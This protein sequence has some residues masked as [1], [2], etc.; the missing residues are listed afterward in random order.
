MGPKAVVK[1]NQEGKIENE[2]ERVRHFWKWSVA[3]PWQCSTILS[4]CMSSLF[5]FTQE[6]KPKQWLPKSKPGPVNA[7]VHTTRTKQMI[8]AFFDSKG[9]V[10][11]NHMPKGPPWTLATLWM[12]WTCSWR[13]WRRRGGWQWQSKAGGSW[14]N[15]PVH[16]TA[17][18]TNWMATRQIKWLNTDL[19]YFPGWRQS[20][21]AALSP[22]QRWTSPRCT[23]SGMSTEKRV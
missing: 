5:H 2:C 19:F 22:S 6:I 13:C 3:A 9:L 18:V 1:R 12:S 7:K 10:Y 20:W 16:T 8:L 4:P 23:A 14:N 17:A 21:L 11:T 15:A